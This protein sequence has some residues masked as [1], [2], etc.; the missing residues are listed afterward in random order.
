[1]GVDAN[2]D[3]VSHFPPMH[4]AMIQHHREA[5]HSSLATN[6]S[7]ALSLTYVITKGVLQ[8]LLILLKTVDVE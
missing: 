3:K 7:T 2:S 8:L 6:F 1:M 5:Y 4:A